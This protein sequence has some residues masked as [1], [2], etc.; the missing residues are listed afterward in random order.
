MENEILDHYQAIMR[1]DDQTRID[2]ES[3]YNQYKNKQHEQM[4]F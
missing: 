1:Y 2:A 4:V 3:L